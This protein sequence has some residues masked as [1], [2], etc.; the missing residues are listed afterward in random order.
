MRRLN[1]SQ[2]S[3]IPNN[4]KN[5]SKENI[6]IMTFEWREAAIENMDSLRLPT[7]PIPLKQFHHNKHTFS[8]PII[9]HFDTS[10]LKTPSPTHPH[11]CYCFL[12]ALFNCFTSIMCIYLFHNLVWLTQFSRRLNNLPWTCAS[13]ELVGHSYS[14]RW[15]HPEWSMYTEIKLGYKRDEISKL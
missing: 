11:C 7:R 4:H 8:A 10:A 14:S 1:P 2:Y 12:G 3:P 13:W 9:F 15:E 5:N 6:N